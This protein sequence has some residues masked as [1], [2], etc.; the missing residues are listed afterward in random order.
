M[1]TFTICEDLDEMPHHAAFHQGLHC[2]LRQ[3]SSDKNIQYFKKNYNLTP[4]DI[5]NGLSQV[6]CMEPEGRIH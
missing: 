2:L 5:Y 4:I 6:Y 1:G 3:K